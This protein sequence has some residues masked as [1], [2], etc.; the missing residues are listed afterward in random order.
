MNIVRLIIALLS[1]ALLVWAIWVEP[2]SL[3]ISSYS[4]PL[5]DK[6]NRH[7]DG[8][9]IA[10][11]A[12]L[13]VG[14]PHIT[15]DK[16]AQIVAMTNAAAPDLILLP[17]DFVAH[18]VG[19]RTIPAMEIANALKPLNAPMGVYAVLGNHDWWE[20]HDTITQALESAGIIVLENKLTTLPND[21]KLVGLSDVHAGVFDSSVIPHQGPVLCM[22]HTPDA[23]PDLPD[24]CFLTV[25]GHTH[26]GQ[27]R[28]PFIPPFWTPSDY[29]ARYAAGWITEGARHL[30]VSTGIGTSIFPLRLGV[31]PEISLLTLKPAPDGE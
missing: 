9:T 4:L 2:R 21:L 3:R 27:I 23:F 6:S 29:R 14:S 28:L 5:L 24:A 20:D 13:H 16:V 12:D 17:G 26:G 15:L 19:G 30:F 31:P 7:L 1:L 25:A 18:V 22:T 8:M 10:V 11:V